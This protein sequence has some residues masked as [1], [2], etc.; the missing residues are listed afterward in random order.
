M[1]KVTKPGET[2]PWG[3]PN[4]QCGA[5]GKLLKKIIKLD[6]AFDMNVLHYSV[7]EE[8]VGPESLLERDVSHR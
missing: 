2:K 1:K 4:Y 3:G 8:T 7:S 5:S 6:R